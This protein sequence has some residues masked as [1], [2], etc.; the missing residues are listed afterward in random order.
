MATTETQ[1]TGQEMTDGV[2][3]RYA[4]SLM[5]LDCLHDALTELGDRDIDIRTADPRQV[6]AA[7]RMAAQNFPSSDPA[8]VAQLAADAIGEWDDL[9]ADEVSNSGVARAWLDGALEI[10]LTG[11]RSLGDDDWTT[12]G[13]EVLLG[14]GGPNV[15]LRA[16][17]GHLTLA[18]DWWY[19]HAERDICAPSIEAELE[20]IAEQYS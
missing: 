1:K 4:Q 7:C 6:A 12:E 18:V 17:N 10:K 11:Y 19:D 13:V 20:Q 5:A 2:A 16:R 8:T 15:R 14:F 9:D 3:D